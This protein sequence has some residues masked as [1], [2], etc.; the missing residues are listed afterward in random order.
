MA[1]MASAYV[2]MICLPRLLATDPVVFRAGSLGVALI[3]SNKI[4]PISVIHTEN[5]KSCRAGPL[6]KSYR[7]PPRLR[8]LPARERPEFVCQE[9]TA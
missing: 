9:R 8:P 6:F 1:L 4:H 7:F 2:D 5:V 3:F